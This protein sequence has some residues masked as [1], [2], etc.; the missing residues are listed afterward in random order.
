MEEKIKLSF[1]SL[2]S[3]FLNYC[4]FVLGLKPSELGLRKLQRNTIHL[5]TMRLN[6]DQYLKENLF[7]I[8]PDFLDLYIHSK[9]QMRQTHPDE[10]YKS[11]LS[12][13]E[14]EQVFQY[15]AKNLAEEYPQYFTYSNGEFTSLREGES[16][17]LRSICNKDISFYRDPID[18]IAF[19]IQED[20]CIVDA[21][22]LK[23]KLVHLCSPN[24]WTA[25]WGIDK[26]FDQLHLNTPRAKEILKRPELVFQRI[27]K[28]GFQYERLGA[29]TLTSFPYLLRHPHHK[30]IPIGLKTPYFYFRFERQ[31]LSAIDNSNLLLFTIRPYLTDFTELIKEKLS[32][33]DL[34]DI[35]KGENRSRYSWFFE[36][37]SDYFRNYLK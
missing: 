25:K 6:Q 7:Q 8:D 20:F 18:F 17:S 12:T 16:T 3:D 36:A 14:Q 31:T 2:N 5:D 19:H 35:L 27:F 13:T 22:T 10:D 15:M 1:E 9:K 34:E 32:K 29:M 33:S 11:L 23:T 21:A 28:S 30:E 24:D 37:N 26:D 4:P